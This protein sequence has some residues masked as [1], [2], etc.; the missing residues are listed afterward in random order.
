MVALVQA[1]VAA[2]EAPICLGD[3][4][5]MQCSVAEHS[6]NC[7]LDALGA[8]DCPG[9]RSISE[10]PRTQHELTADLPAVLLDVGKRHG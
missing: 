3:S 2:F 8:I 4:R 7:E 9:K 5:E 6:W 1:T 10:K